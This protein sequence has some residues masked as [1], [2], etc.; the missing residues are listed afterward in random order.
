MGGSG[1]AALAGISAG[2]SGGHARKR[3]VGG[4]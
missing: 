3:M 2:G 4:C 1:R